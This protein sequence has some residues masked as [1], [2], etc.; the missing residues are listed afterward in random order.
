MVRKADLAK[1]NSY[2]VVHLECSA[3]MMTKAMNINFHPRRDDLFINRL[4]TYLTSILPLKVD[5]ITRIKDHV[6]FVET[7]NLNFILKAYRSLAKLEFQQ[8]FTTALKK[9]G[10]IET[11]SF[12]HF[13]E[14]P[15]YFEN[16]YYGCLDYLE[17]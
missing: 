10:F 11:Y 1:V 17:P 3:L 13:T 5:Q 8:N 15:L 6:F 7:K 4:F 16:L 14:A 12:Y 9:V 2:Q